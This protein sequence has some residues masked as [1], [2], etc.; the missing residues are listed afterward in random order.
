MHVIAVGDALLKQI[1]VAETQPG[2]TRVVLDLEQHAEFTAS[3]LSS[4]DRLM[5]ELRA[6][7]PARSAADGQCDADA[8]ER[9]TRP[10]VPAGRERGSWSRTAF[11]D[12][13]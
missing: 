7:G 13:V 10:P 12:G 11:I 4:P 1:R 9:C 3:Q 8:N 6:E 2:V 5:I